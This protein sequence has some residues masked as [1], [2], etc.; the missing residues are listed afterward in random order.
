MPRITR[1]FATRT[2]FAAAALVLVAG[3]T[4]TAEACKHGRGYGSG[5]GNY[6][7]SYNTGYYRVQQVP[8][9]PPV[10]NHSNAFPQQIQQQQVSPQQFP[11]Q[12]LQRQQFQGQQIQ[13]QAG[14]Q[15]QQPIVQQ[16]ANAAPQPQTS[17]PVANS[18][19]PSANLN[20]ALQALG[21]PVEQVA[22]QPAP[23]QTVASQQL[24][25]HVGTFNAVLANGAKV[26]LTLESN[27]QFTWSAVNGKGVQSSFS[28]TYQVGT[29][30]LTLIRSND[31]IRLAGNLSNLNNS[32]FNFQLG[33]TSA[34]LKFVRS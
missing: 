3:T 32:G 15:P 24:P 21:G 27:G 25:G 13:G 23:Q 1:L 33:N 2:L 9:A 12:P 30:S 14:G 22:Q 31:N 29:D 11:Q 17:A 28:G 6:R 5:Y 19:Q 10:I 34:S 16:P 7:P 8:Q 18:P 4:T 20:A 26:E